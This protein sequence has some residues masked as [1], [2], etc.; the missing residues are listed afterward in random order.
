MAQR[1]G[2]VFA[3]AIGTAVFNSYGGL[4]APE[5]VTQ[6]FRPAIWACAAFAGLA[7]VAALAMSPRRRTAAELEPVSAVS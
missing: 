5:A 6:G 1:F 3:V 7:T 4:G 2:A